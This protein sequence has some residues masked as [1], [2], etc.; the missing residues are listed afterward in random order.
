MGFN[1]INKELKDKFEIIK[2]K[3]AIPQDPLGKITKPTLAFGE[4]PYQI[5]YPK[6]SKD[7]E[8]DAPCEF[9]KILSTSTY[10]S[11]GYESLEASDTK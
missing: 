4:S 6:S 2:R 11:L 1:P 7:T 3:L 9:S 5:V 10:Q 8:E